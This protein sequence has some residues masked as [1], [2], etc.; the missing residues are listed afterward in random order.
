MSYSLLNVIHIT[1]KS[2]VN[3]VHQKYLHVYLLVYV[4]T[5]TSTNSKN[6]KPFTYDNKPDI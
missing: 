6:P 5:D 2:V 4:F 3:Y 1:H